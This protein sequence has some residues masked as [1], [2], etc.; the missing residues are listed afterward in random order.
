MRSITGGMCAALLGLLAGCAGT[1]ERVAPMAATAPVA[2]EAAVSALYDRIGVATSNFQGGLELVRA[3]RPRDGRG[4]MRSALAEIE[5]AALSCSGTPG[6]DSERFVGAFVVLVR[7]QS[8]AAGW[9]DFIDEEEAASEGQLVDLDELPVL[10]EVER[11]VRLLKGRELKDLIVL[12]EPV[13]AA[14]EDWLTWMRPQLIEAW[15]NYQFLRAD[16]YPAYEQAGLPEAVLFAILAKESAGRVH[17][18]SRAG[19]AG[20][21]QF[22][23]ATAR[24]FGLGGTGFDERLDPTLVA[25][26]NAAYIE[27]QLRVFNDNLEL[28]LAAYNGGEGRL[29]RLAKQNPGRGFWSERIFFALPAETRDYVPKVLAAAYLFLH[30]EQYGL[31]FPVVDAAVAQLSLDRELSLGELAICLG[32]DERPDGWFR[33]LRNLN[34]RL[35]PEQRLPP[36]SSIRVPAKL[37]E[38]YPQ[39]CGDA[40]FLA[41]ISALQDARHPSG[42]TEVGYTVRRGDTLAAISRRTRC[43]SVREIAQLNGIR[44][45]KYS[46][47]VGQKLRLPTCS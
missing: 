30:P 3:G 10:P 4:Q 31:K 34:P 22:M 19:A 36:G 35:K 44:G 28:S 2:D 25:R 20:P 5:N 15:L 7:L 29:S 26:A 41:R 47:S 13:R 21:L 24:R 39:R 6:C 16:M 40:D 37:V 8:V 43:S 17:A 9:D 18:F 23:P 27:E 45:P 42:P 14:L 46:L 38:A 12:N 33:T 1:P 32:Q 11:S